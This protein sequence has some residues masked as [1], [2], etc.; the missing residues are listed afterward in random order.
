MSAVLGWW[1]VVAFVGAGGGWIAP[2]ML[3]RMWTGQ[4]LFRWPLGAALRAAAPGWHR[5]VGASCLVL[6]AAAWV[7]LAERQG[8]AAALSAGILGML[9]LVVAIDDL[10]TMCVDWGVL[11]VVGVVALGWR[12]AR[13]DGGN[14]VGVLAASAAG[15]SAMGGGAVAVALGYWA[16]RGRAGLGMGDVLMAV[17]IGMCFDGALRWWVLTAACAGGPVVAGWAAVARAVAPGLAPSGVA[18]VGDDAGA[19]LVPKGPGFATAVYG[20]LFLAS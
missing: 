9:L 19:V 10:V 7:G 11:V 4:A 5:I 13:T 12:L 15:G 2:T 18:R 3:E 1:L 8:G 20:G 17:V 16:L 14:L 6:V